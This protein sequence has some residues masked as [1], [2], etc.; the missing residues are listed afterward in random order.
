MTG[1]RFIEDTQ[2]Q[3]DP[4]VGLWTER[5]AVTQKGGQNLLPGSEAMPFE[6]FEPPADLSVPGFRGND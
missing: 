1:W 6:Q 3:L 2:R 5:I 4:S